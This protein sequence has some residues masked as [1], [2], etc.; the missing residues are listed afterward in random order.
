MRV[1]S[2]VPS[3]VRDL[4]WLRKTNQLHDVLLEECV[5]RDVR[6]EEPVAGLSATSKFAG[7]AHAL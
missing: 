2:G 5:E 7:H 1:I 4:E 6:L 3:R